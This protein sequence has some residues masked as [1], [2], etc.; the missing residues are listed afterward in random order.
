MLWEFSKYVTEMLVHDLLL[1]VFFLMCDMFAKEEFIV[2]LKNY[3]KEKIC[4][5]SSYL[6]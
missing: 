3:M 2:S 6:K 4:S 5:I 1:I